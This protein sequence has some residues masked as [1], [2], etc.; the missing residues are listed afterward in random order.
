MG[1]K[2]MLIKVHLFIKES[3]RED[4]GKTLGVMERDL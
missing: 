4:K 2:S 1:L 3:I